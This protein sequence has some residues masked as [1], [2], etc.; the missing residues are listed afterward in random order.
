MFNLNHR[1]VTEARRQGHDIW[2]RH[3]A[4]RSLNMAAALVELNL[5]IDETLFGVGSW[6]PDPASMFDRLVK[7]GLNE[8][9][10][11]DPRSWRDT[12]LGRA[13]Q[14]N[15]YSTFLGLFEMSEIPLMLEPLGLLSKADCENLWDGLETGQDMSSWTRKK[16]QMAYRQYFGQT[17]AS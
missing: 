9:V 5:L 8:T 15:L 16:L 12:D 17:R 13:V 6:P 11:G 14:I 10:P 2:R 3:S 4:E 7:L 1:A